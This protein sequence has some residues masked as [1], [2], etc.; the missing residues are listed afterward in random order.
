MI[1]NKKTIVELTLGKTRVDEN[2]FYF[3]F[4]EIQLD[5]VLLLILG[6]TFLV[7]GI[8]RYLEIIEKEVY[9]KPWFYITIVS[10]LFLVISVIILTFSKVLLPLKI[11]RALN[12]LSFVSFTV[13]AFLFVFSLIYLL[14][15]L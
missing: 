14:F 2:K 6:S 9:I 12:S 4:S 15:V 1:K 10:I 13:G 11:K 3:S 5:A 8:I 7:Q